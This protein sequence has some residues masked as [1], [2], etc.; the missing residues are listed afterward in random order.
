MWVVAFTVL[1]R[2]LLRLCAL[3]QKLCLLVSSPTLISV[4]TTTTTTGGNTTITVGPMA[5][6]VGTYS[7]RV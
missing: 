3:Y 7:S 5:L 4:P 2:L 6:C 1:P